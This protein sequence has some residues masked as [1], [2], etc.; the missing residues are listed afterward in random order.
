MKPTAY[1][2]SMRAKAKFQRAKV[3]AQK[4]K[5]VSRIGDKHAVI[6][7]DQTD[8]VSDTIAPNIIPVDSLADVQSAV[9]QDSTPHNVEA[10]RT[11]KYEADS[12]WHAEAEWEEHQLLETE[13][14]E[15]SKGKNVEGKR[16]K[17][18][19][20]SKGKSTPRPTTL[21]PAKAQNPQSDRPPP[22]PKPEA[23]SC[24]AEG[25]MFAM[26]STKSKPTWRHATWGSTDYMVCTVADPHLTSN[27]VMVFH[28]PLS[29]HCMNA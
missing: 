22:K 12:A 29:Q 8:A 25:Y 20:K 28:W 21:R 9:Q 17:S 24:V 14:Y 5:E 15:A 3:K 16:S 2:E 6:I 1:D 26:M 23:R 18:K 7:G 13:E 4:A 11:T 27:L 19:G 10:Q